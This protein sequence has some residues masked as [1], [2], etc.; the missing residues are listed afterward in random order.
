MSKEIIL[1]ESLIRDNDRYVINYPVNHPDKV[2]R[3]HKVLKSGGCSTKMAAFRL[4]GFPKRVYYLMKMA[5]EVGLEYCDQNN[6]NYRN[7]NYKSVIDTFEM[8][9]ESAV[10]MGHE[11][12]QIAVDHTKDVWGKDKDGNKI[13]LKKGNGELALKIAGKFIEELNDKTTVD[14]NVTNKQQF[15]VSFNMVEFG[16]VID[17]A[18]EEQ[19]ELL[20]I[21][22]EKSK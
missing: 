17:I 18:A 22:M 6:I 21:T 14:V 2:T 4:S 3:L 13:L 12:L 16:D 5:S 1:P 10:F 19:A 9:E 11:M 15:G 8:L 7:T 20:R